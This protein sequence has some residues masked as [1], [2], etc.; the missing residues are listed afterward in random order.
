MPGPQ[1]LNLTRRDCLQLA[2]VPTLASAASPSEIDFRYAPAQQQAAYCFPDDP[3]KSLIDERGRLLYGN[4]GRKG[5]D[6]YP[7]VVEFS[8]QGMGEFRVVRQSLES[9]GVPIITTGFERPGS[10]GFQLTTFATNRPGEGRVDNVILS[11]TGS[12]GV[13]VTIRTRAQLKL[14]GQTATL[15]GAPF[16]VLDRKP[17]LRDLGHAWLLYL[18]P[19][20]TGN[21]ALLRFPQQAQSLS[22]ASLDELLAW[23]RAWWK[24]WTPFG[25]DLDWHLPKP[26]DDFLRACARNILQAREARQGRLTFQV[27]PTCYRGLWVVDGHFILESARY[28]GYHKEAVEGLRTTWTYQRPDGALDA[29]GGPEHYKDAAIAIFSTV[30]QCE[31]SQDWTAFQDL[32]PSITRAAA[33]LRSRQ[34]PAHAGLIVPGFADGGFMKGYE[35]TNTLWTLAGLRAAAAQPGME[36]LARFHS[37]LRAAFDKA[38]ASEMVRHPASFDYLPMVMREDPTWQRSEWERP[39]PQAAQWALSQAIF[40]GVEFDP[41]SPVVRGHIALMKSCTQEDVPIETGWLPHQGLWT[42]NAA[43]VAHAYLWAGEAEW[44]RRT[45]LGFLNHATP[46]YCWREEQPLRGS[47]LAGYIGDM[48]HNWASA[49]CVL[50]LR[51]M[52]ALEDGRALRLL[53]GIGQA[54]LAYREPF[55]LRATP[56]RFGPLDLELTPE[57]RGWRLSYRRGRGPTPDSLRLPALL[58]TA[59]SVNVQ[60]TQSK[61]NGRIIEIDPAA[62]SFT[63]TWTR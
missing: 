24:A 50:Y 26:Y 47:A 3:H 51:H 62:E 23:A 61:S 25:P 12:A 11:S 13:L 37:Q 35:L 55:R 17:A 9:P 39:R 40:P 34:D 29:G 43:F 21:T 59:R 6:F 31:L 38:A 60:G 63:A 32:A 2:A 20:A 53:A 4:P 10:P 7:T 22:P 16:L 58:G 18:P 54:D 5:A 30:R 56:T 44:A 41:A 48:P 19:A 49:E 8:L 15:D 46:L 52:L 1:V 42:Y 28:L 36:E 27:G 45:F 33:F 57:S 14:D